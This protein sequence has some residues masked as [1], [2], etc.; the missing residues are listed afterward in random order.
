[1]DTLPFHSYFSALSRDEQHSKKTS[2]G[3]LLHPAEV[4][5]SRSNELF[6]L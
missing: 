2:V 3:F 5:R 6:L 1:M 4:F